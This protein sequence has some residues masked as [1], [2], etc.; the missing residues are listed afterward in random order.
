MSGTVAEKGGFDKLAALCVPAG[1]GVIRKPAIPD[2]TS[3]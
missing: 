3:G 2:V 1:Q